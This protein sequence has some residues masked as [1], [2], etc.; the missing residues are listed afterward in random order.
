MSNLQAYRNLLLTFYFEWA[1]T[2]LF[3]IK[4]HE[5]SFIIHRCKPYKNIKATFSMVR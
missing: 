2:A 4:Y 1:R 3:T 5:N